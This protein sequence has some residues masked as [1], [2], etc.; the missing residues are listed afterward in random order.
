M[1]VFRFLASLFLLIATVAL[2]S[3]ATPTT[4]QDIGFAPTSI[5]KHWTDLA[6]TSLA[7]T[8]DGVVRATSQGFW[9][10]VVMTVLAIP[11]FV[12]FGVL[13][14]LCGFLGRRRHRVDIYVN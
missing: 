14:L 1:A 7:A 13:A 12:F 11:T 8:R 10:N 9:D 5:S 2:V 3:D 6:P 4:Y